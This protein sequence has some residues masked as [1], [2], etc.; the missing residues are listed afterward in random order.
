MTYNNKKLIEALIDSLK[1]ELRFQ[2]IECL[3]KSLIER[4]LKA[5]FNELRVHDYND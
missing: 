1:R 5:R 3:A 2:Y 4:N